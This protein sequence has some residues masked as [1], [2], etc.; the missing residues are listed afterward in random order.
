MSVRISAVVCTYN[1]AKLVGQAIDSLAGQNLDKDSFEIIIVDNGST[2]STKDIVAPKIEKLSNVRYVVE[3][4]LGLSHARN[5]G[6]KKARGKYV[7]FLD[8]DAIADQSWL[9]NIISAFER[10]GG[11]GI[12]GGK[13]SPVWSKEPEKWVKKELLDSLSLLNWSDEDIF[14]EPGQWLCGT[15]IAYLRGLL[16]KYCGFCPTL[17]RKGNSL[18]SNEEIYLNKRI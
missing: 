15:N 10:N 13:I 4:T 2:D 1:R 16:E 9:K 18:M 17:G 12:V 6:W 7:A 14:L 3:P 5:L 8:D 11:A